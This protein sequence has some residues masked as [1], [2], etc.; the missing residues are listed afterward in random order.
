MQEILIELGLNE[1]QADT[2]LYLLAKGDSTPPQL[3]SALSM[4][5]TNAYKVLNSLEELTLVH[6]TE[7]NKKLVYGASDPTALASLVA[8]KRNAVLALEQSTRSAMQELRK[9]YRNSKSTSTSFVKTGKSAMMDA[10]KQQASKYQPIYFIRS[11]A[12][13]PFMG[14]DAMN[15]VRT[16]VSG[17][18]TPRYGITPDGIESP[19]NPEIDNRANLTRTWLAAEDY[20]S[21][22]EWSVSGGTL[23]IHVFDGE[24]RVVVIDDHEIATAFLQIWQLLDNKTRQSKEYKHLPKLAGRKI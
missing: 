5:R 24:G 7:V 23:L 12:D 22:V 6:K 9:L 20:T 4:T 18:A 2:Y 14:F 17:T 16:L 1:L 10:Y 3:A 11:R 15:E 19:I 21:P 13:I 8:E